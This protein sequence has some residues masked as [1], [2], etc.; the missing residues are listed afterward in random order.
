MSRN[1]SPSQSAT[2]PASSISHKMHTSVIFLLP[3]LPHTSEDPH[4]SIHMLASNKLFSQ[5]GNFLFQ[6]ITSEATTSI[7]LRLSIM[8]TMS[9]LPM[10]KQPLNSSQV[11]CQANSELEQTHTVLLDM[12]L[13]HNKSELVALLVLVSTGHK[14]WL[15][16]T[17]LM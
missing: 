3:D 12:D 7:K 14:E 5:N 6:E 11:T 1:H 9:S 15:L 17:R 16:V 2:S 8:Q 10:V 4:P 13:V